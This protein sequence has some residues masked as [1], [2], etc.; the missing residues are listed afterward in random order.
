MLDY[1]EYYNESRTH[2][3]LGNDCPVPRAMERSEV[4][5]IRQRSIGGGLHHRYY[6]AA[7]ES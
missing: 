3:S 1:V 2:L 7:A 5:L 6:R 4:G